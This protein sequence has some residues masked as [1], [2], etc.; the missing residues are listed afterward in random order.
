MSTA[1]WNI[2]GHR[3]LCHHSQRGPNLSSCLR[4]CSDRHQRSQGR[5]L[6][7]GCRGAPRGWAHHAGPCPLDA[8]LWQG[9]GC[10]G[11]ATSQW[12]T[13]WASG[14]VCLGLWGGVGDLPICPATSPPVSPSHWCLSGLGALPLHA[15]QL[16]GTERVSPSVHK[17]RQ[18]RPLGRTQS[19]PLPQNAPALQHLVIQQQHQQFLEKHKQHFQQQLHMNKVGLWAQDWWGPLGGGVAQHVPLTSWRALPFREQTPTGSPQLSTA[20]SPKSTLSKPPRTCT[21]P[22]GGTSPSEGIVCRTAFRGVRTC[23]VPKAPPTAAC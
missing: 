4:C 1:F 7:E 18:H 23:V 22:P 16:V 6:P 2:P 17:L 9:P 21:C 19:A 13:L 15:Q 12:P 11:T 10:Q 20:R 14:S 8:H 5:G 3:N